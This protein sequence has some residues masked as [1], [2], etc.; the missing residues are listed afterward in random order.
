ME[1]L[2]DMKQFLHSNHWVIWVLLLLTLWDGIWK[3]V[4]MWKAARNNQLG[5]FIAIAIFN[6]IG[7][8]PMIYMVLINKKPSTPAAEPNK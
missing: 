2:T 4:A 5:W 1:T 6:T 8:L 7:I 3:I